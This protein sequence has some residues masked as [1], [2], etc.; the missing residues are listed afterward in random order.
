L[1]TNT[2]SA[3]EFAARLSGFQETGPLPGP[4]AAETGA[5]LTDATGTLQFSIDTSSKTATYK[6]SYSSGF[7]SPITQAH[8]EKLLNEIEPRSA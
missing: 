1:V 8:T 7:T 6:L 4:T 2:A 5:I 3:Q